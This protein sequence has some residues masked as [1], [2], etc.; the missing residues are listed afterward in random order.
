VLL[1]DGEVVYVKLLAATDLPTACAVLTCLHAPVLA[2]RFAAVELL[3]SLRRLLQFD[4]I[5]TLNDQV[6]EN[7]RVQVDATDSSFEVAQVLPAASLARNVPGTTYSI[8][9]LPDDSSQGKAPARSDRRG[10]IAGRGGCK[11][12][13]SRFTSDRGSSSSRRFTCFAVTGTFSCTLKYTVKDCD[14]NTGVADD[15]GYEDEYALE[16]VDVVVADHV[17]RTPLANFGAEWEELGPANELADTFAL[18]QHKTL[19]G[20]PRLP[21]APARSLLLLRAA[22][23]SRKRLVVCAVPRALRSPA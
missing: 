2:Q 4:C 13:D 17:Q 8:V 3:T 21:C 1:S 9:N 12:A 22:I 10:V 19:D 14:P 5:N 23:A 16:D 15:D 7:V 18:A 11:L 6:L 20:M